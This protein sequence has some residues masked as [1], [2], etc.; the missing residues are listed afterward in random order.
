MDANSVLLSELEDRF[1]SSDVKR[2]SIVQTKFELRDDLRLW[3]DQ[4]E[5]EATRSADLL[6]QLA[7]RETENAR[8]LEQFREVRT[9]MQESQKEKQK[10]EK[11]IEGMRSRRAST[12]GNFED[13]Y[14]PV[15]G[16]ESRPSAPGGLR[17][18]KLGRTGSIP[19]LTAPAPAFSKR[20]SSLGLQTVLATEDHKPL[21]DEAL[22]LELVNAKTSEA[23][24]RQE[25]EEV[26]GK[27]DSLRRMLGGP[28]SPVNGHRPS[29][30]EP[31]VARNVSMS[32]STA[33]R[34]SIARAAPESLK[35]ATPAASS[36]GFF[37]GWGKRTISNPAV[38]GASPEAAQH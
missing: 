31:C 13:V 27:L 35:V 19:S 36:G 6:R 21:A 20:S 2:S 34:P 23:V 30:S 29:P 25:L 1:E 28:S 22:L 14:T 8:V 12:A 18:F 16:P 10:L 24:A 3:K 15:D 37:S 4:Y 33:R 32:A 11:W 7:D 17:E 38:N 5:I 26:K 9:R